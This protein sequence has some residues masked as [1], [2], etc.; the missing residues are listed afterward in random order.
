MRVRSIVMM[1]VV[2]TEQVVL[3]RVTA[4]TNVIET[5]LRP[6][7]LKMGRIGAVLDGN[8]RLCP[9]TQPERNGGP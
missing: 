3:G 2:W 5:F 4:L 8:M 9:Q 6:V 7:L 1:V